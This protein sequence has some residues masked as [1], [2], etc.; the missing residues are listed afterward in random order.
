MP[1]QMSLTESVEEAGDE[2]EGEEEVVEE[3]VAQE[4]TGVEL[5]VVVGEHW[6]LVTVHCAFAAR[7]QC[8]N[9]SCHN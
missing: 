3:E 8:L 4:E 2:A 5:V 7:K 1:E 9:V 6:E